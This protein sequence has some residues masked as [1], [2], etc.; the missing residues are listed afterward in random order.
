MNKNQYN[1][2]KIEKIFNRCLRLINKGY[3]VEY[4][5]GK[6]NRYRGEL[7]EYLN[8]ISN[9]K[10]I[11]NIEPEGKNTR[12]ILERIYSSV[13]NGAEQDEHE[14][15]SNAIVPHYS[16][17]ASFLKPVTVFVMVLV[18]AI[19]SFTG[20]VYAS[21]DSLPGEN[22]YPVKR[23]A[24]NIQL[25]FYPESKKGQL[26]FNFLNNRI[27][28]ASTLMEA[29]KDGNAELIKELLLEVDEE[30]RK[31]KKYDFF[32]IANEEDTLTIINNINSRYRN[33]YEQH[34]EDI[35]KQ[36]TYNETPGD[37]ESMHN[38][39]IHSEENTDEYE[40]NQNKKGSEK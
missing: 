28:E 22:L 18:L 37:S 39:N 19:F 32:K 36:D 5:L 11:K 38:E 7:E 30:Y 23:T 27:Y 4:C 35:E 1:D 9:L 31:C 26:H 24:E 6:Y 34:N 14:I 33:K 25:F 10:N 40:R 29:D 16:M 20:T 8:I 12:S 2:K 15:K 3:S 13:S 17:R 21:Q